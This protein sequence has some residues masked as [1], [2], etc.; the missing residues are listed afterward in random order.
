MPDT[1]PNLLPC[2]FCGSTRVCIDDSVGGAFISCDLCEA[3]GPFVQYQQVNYPASMLRS[4]SVTP[5][6]DAINPPVTVVGQSNEGYKELRE[7]ATREAQS[8]AIAAWN[9]RSTWQPIETAPRDK[10][11]RLWGK[12]ANNSDMP[13]REITGQ[14][15]EGQSAWSEWCEPPSD[16]VGPEP[17]SGI[18]PTHWQPLPSPPITPNPHA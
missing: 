7:K 5:N 2:P 1:T 10:P 3:Q 16:W 15:H 4:I 12:F 11:L 9:Q 14:W 8:A 6:G 13:S 17:F 18:H